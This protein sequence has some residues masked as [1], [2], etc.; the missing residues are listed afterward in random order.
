M[1]GNSIIAAEVI[2]LT[3]ELKLY[4]QAIDNTKKVHRGLD[5][6][7]RTL[8]SEQLFRGIYY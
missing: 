4:Y 1:L 7:R 3:S 8:D 5:K 2:K 6:G